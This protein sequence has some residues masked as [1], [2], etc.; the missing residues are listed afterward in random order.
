MALGDDSGM[1]RPAITSAVVRNPWQ[2]LRPEGILDGTILGTV[3]K[4]GHLPGRFDSFHAIA[5]QNETTVDGANAF[6]YRLD[7][8]V[9]E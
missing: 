8:V 3:G 5:G 6:G 2:S 7:K 9:I 1:A 4:L